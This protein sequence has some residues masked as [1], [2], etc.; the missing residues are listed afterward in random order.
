MGRKSKKEGIFVYVQLSHFDVQQ[1][2]TQHC[3]AT[4][5]QK[6]F[7]FLK[8]TM[9][10]A[11]QVALVIKNQPANTGDIREAGSIPGS[12]RSLG[13]G[14]GNSLQYSCLENPTAE[15][16]DGLQS[17]GSQRVGHDWNDLAYRHA[18]T[19]INSDYHVLPQISRMYSFY[20]WQYHL[21]NF[22]P[23]PFHLHSLVSII[24]FSIT[25][26]LTCF[27]K[28]SIYTWRKDCWTSLKRKDLL[29]EL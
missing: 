18:F 3:K 4:I 28:D 8:Y 10:K 23:L 21:M 29:W 14:S 6:G 22:S 13:G 16:P 19:N 20:N 17:I 27:L 7:F 12:G 1:K 15:N 24:L 9:H 2:L 25:L 26:S 5:F 11:S